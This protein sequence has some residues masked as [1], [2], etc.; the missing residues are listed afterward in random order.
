MKI[1]CSSL[2]TEAKLMKTKLMTVKLNHLDLRLL[3]TSVTATL[4]QAFHHMLKL[5][6]S[7]L[8]SL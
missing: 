4:Y 3:G 7:D 5:K 2:V 6:A 1:C 8:Q